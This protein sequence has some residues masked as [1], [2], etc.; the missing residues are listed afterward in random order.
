MVEW[1]YWTSENS[2]AKPFPYRVCQLERFA[3]TLT[4]TATAGL[5]AGVPPVD[6]LSFC[7]SVRIP[8]LSLFF[9]FFFFFPFSLSFSLF[10]PNMFNVVTTHLPYRTRVI[11]PSLSWRRLG[12]GYV[13]KDTVTH[14][15]C[16]NRKQEDS[17]CHF[18]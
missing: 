4:N 11:A 8:T 17:Q 5:T 10:L 1:L 13:K 6:D 3:F 16:T 18:I 15:Q 2:H 9:F 12:T 14:S 7:S